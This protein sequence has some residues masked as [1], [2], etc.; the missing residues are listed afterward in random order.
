MR[1]GTQSP[2]RHCCLLTQP[3]TLRPKQV[4]SPLATAAS[5]GVMTSAG[6]CGYAVGSV[7][8]SCPVQAGRCYQ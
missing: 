8:N 5:R 2:A 1:H 3:G 4:T 6:F 7:R